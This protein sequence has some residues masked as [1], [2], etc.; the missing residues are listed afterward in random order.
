MLSPELEKQYNIFSSFDFLAVED[1]IIPYFEDI[2]LDYFDCGQGF[3]EDT[4]DF[5]VCLQSVNQFYKVTVN[6]DVA[7]AKQERGERLYWVDGINK[8]T[9]IKIDEPKLKDTTKRTIAVEAYQYNKAI[10]I[11]C[12]AGI[13]VV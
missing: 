11:L 8:I 10:D 6:I 9:F 4:K 5:I 2:A 12:K 3:Y 1:D 13:S 7:S